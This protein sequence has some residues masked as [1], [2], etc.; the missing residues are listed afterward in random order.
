MKFNSAK[1]WT[2]WESLMICVTGVN[3][4]V[5]THCNPHVIIII[6]WLYRPIQALASPFGVS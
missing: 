1:I 6:I 4:W 3:E 2:Q 5:D